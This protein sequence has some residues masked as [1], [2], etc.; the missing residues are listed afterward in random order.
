MEKYKNINIIYEDNHLLIVVKPNNMPICQDSSKDKDLLN[1]MKEYLK[2]KYQKKGNVYLG[3]VH[4]IDRPVSGIIVFAKTSKSAD[5]LTKQIQNKEFKKTYYAIV[6]NKIANQDTLI[7]YIKKDPITHKSYI[8]SEGKESI[9]KYQKIK[10]INS[11]N[12]IKINLITGRHH[13]IRIQFSSRN[14]PLYGDHLYNKSFISDNKT[15]IALIAKKVEFIHP[16]TKENLTFEIDLPKE[17]PW[18]LF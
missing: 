13:Q 17:Y 18:N 3:L 16:T 9:L 5:R 15:N 2:I 8:S 4:R 10:T 12:L 14:N 1:I 6:E 11:L 7:D